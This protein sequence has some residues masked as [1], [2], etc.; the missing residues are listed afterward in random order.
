[1]DL[2][3]VRQEMLRL[4]SYGR[5]ETRAITRLPFSEAYWG[6]AKLLRQDM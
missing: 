2:T 1:M 6:A 5:G 4:G 3:E